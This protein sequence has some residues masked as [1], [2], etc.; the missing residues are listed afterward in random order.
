MWKLF[1]IENF[2]GLES[3]LVFDQPSSEFLRQ[4]ADM[5]KYNT[6]VWGPV[7][8][9]A[10]LYFQ[11]TWNMWL[12]IITVVQLTPHFIAHGEKYYRCIICYRKV[13]NAI[14]SVIWVNVSNW[15]GKK[16]TLTSIWF[17]Q[18]VFYYTFN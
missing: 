15:G 11:N 18:N 3:C 9:S 4:A 17:E 10:T 14:H 5:M 1:L 2:L 13:K 6:A 8:I 16:I 7:S 12:H